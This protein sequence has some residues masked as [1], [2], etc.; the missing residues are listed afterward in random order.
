M[1]QRYSEHKKYQQQRVGTHARQRDANAW[2]MWAHGA[3]ERSWWH[4]LRTWLGVIFSMFLTIVVPSTVDGS[5][6][7]PRWA[8]WAAQKLGAISPNLLVQAAMQGHAMTEFLTIVAPSTV[9]GS[10]GRPHWAEWAA[11][12]LGAVSPNLL[13]QAAMQGH[14]MTECEVA[15]W[16]L[17]QCLLP[18]S[19]SF[20]LI[21]A[22]G[23]A[24]VS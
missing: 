12:K 1:L 18:L 7:R 13:V 11:Q 14:A 6:G 3:N 22:I 16:L 9:D 2:V 24:K 10:G 19:C 23:G 5:A 8:K 20:S 15:G 21:L 4:T 17:R